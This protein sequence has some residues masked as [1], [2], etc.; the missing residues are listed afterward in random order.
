MT[1]EIIPLFKAA[2]LHA[3]PL[4]RYITINKIIYSIIQA[5]QVLREKMSSQGTMIIFLFYFTWSQN[6]FA[7]L[8]GWGRDTEVAVSGVGNLLFLN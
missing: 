2:Q 4:S 8:A 6:G 1:T 3:V 5:S 7:F